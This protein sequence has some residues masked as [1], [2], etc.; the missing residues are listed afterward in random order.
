MDGVA[1]D[2]LRGVL[3]GRGLGERAHRTLGRAVGP[4][5]QRA[6]EDSG[7]GRHVDDRAASGPAQRRQRLA[8]AE[9]HAQHIHP[10]D[11]F[12]EFLRGVLDLF[13]V[14]DASVVDQN[15]QAAEPALGRG[16][17]VLPVGVAGNVEVDVDR[18]AAALG[19]AP[20]HRLSLVIQNV[21][22]DH[23]CSLG[24]EQLG[25]EG[26]LASGAAGNQYYLTVQPAHYSLRRAFMHL[27]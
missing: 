17:R 15:V 13:V 9:E 24:D 10:H 22:E 16:H 23:P 5:G 19:D 27:I 11:S 2:I 1:T 25:L 26:S 12:P 8:G 21:A 4:A 18:L 6:P 3:D 20:L 14:G 7:D